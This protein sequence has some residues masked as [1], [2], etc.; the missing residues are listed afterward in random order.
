MIVENS[1]ATGETA[2]RCL[3]LMCRPTE[4]PRAVDCFVN[5]NLQKIFSASCMVTVSCCDEV[6]SSR[7]NVL[8]V[9][10]PDSFLFC[11]NTMFPSFS[12]RRIE[13][14]T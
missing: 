9:D 12:A 13:C 7:V 1:C 6:S 14:C 5:A 2:G 8:W 10:D 4:W 3:N 11:G